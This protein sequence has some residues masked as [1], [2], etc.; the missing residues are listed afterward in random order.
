MNIN[1]LHDKLDVD[2][3]T[4]EDQLLLRALLDPVTWSE[5][6][7]KDP[8]NPTRPLD[9]RG[10]QQ[11]TMRYQ[12]ISTINEMGK[13]ILINRIKCYRFGRRTG[14][15][16][17]L[18]VEALWKTCTNHNFKVLY[19]APFESQ[20]NIFFNMIEKL[21]SGTSL[22]PE[23]FVRKPFMCQFKNGSTI[24]A[25]TA[26]VRST[27]KGSTI[28]GAE[29]DLIILD[30]MDHGMDEVV[31]EVIMPIF[32][33]N[34]RATIIAASTPSGRRGLFYLWNVEGEKFRLQ[35]IHYPL[36]QFSSKK[37]S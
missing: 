36:H 13:K 33:G 4:P 24:T 20:C 16:V 1:E 2:E 25:H 18:A 12:P 28:R 3:L 11:S 14:K 8:E 26:N 31:N 27:R 22:Q 19:I 6:S 23:R 7:L 32:M 35:T 30:E 10:Y 9:L 17:E 34:N 5:T 29:G 21:M 37:L 15:T